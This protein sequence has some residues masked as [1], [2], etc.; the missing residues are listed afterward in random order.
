MNQFKAMQMNMSMMC[1]MMM[2]RM[3]VCSKKLY[4]L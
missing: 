3:F 2:C 1:D 4:G